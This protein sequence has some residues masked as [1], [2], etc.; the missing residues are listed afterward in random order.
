MVHRCQRLAKYGALN[1]G[2]NGVM[3]HKSMSHNV[4]VFIAKLCYA[5]VDFF[6]SKRN[7]LSFFWHFL[8]SPIP[9]TVPVNVSNP[10]RERG[11]C[12]LIVWIYN[13]LLDNGENR[14]SY[15]R[16]LVI[17]GGEI[18]G[19]AVYFVGQKFENYVQLA[20]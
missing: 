11:Y 15:R 13:S 9:L 6:F 3:V 17:V 1:N 4:M 7:A 2:L 10:L 18:G 14:E 20:N 8:P 5:Q 12:V 16:K 19:K